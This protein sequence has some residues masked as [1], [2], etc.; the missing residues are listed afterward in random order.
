VRLKISQAHK[1]RGTTP[2]CGIKKGQTGPSHPAYKHGQGKTRD[3]N[4]EKQMA[5]IQAVKFKCN[6]SCFITGET[7][8]KNL[9]CHHLNAWNWAVEQRYD[10][11]NGVLISKQIHKHFHSIFGSQVKTA[12]F[13]QYLIQ[14]QNWGDKPFPWKNGNHEPSLS[15]EEMMNR[16]VAA[17]DKIL[18]EILQRCAS[19][20]FFPKGKNSKSHSIKRNLSQSKIFGYYLL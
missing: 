3:F 11:D 19:L 12:D 15:V 18:G 16:S 8:K 14:Y 13:E 5:W 6:F 9:E 10:V 2:K 7:K 1:K 17:R 4:A 20:W